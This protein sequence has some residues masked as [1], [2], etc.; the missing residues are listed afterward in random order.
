[1]TIKLKS[2][3]VFQIPDGIAVLKKNSIPSER[4]FLPLKRSIADDFPSFFH[5][6]GAIPSSFAP[7]Y[8]YFAHWAEPN[9]E[10][11]E[12][13]TKDVKLPC[14]KSA[15]TLDRSECVGRQNARLRIRFDIPIAIGI[16]SFPFPACRGAENGKAGTSPA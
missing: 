4:R 7:G 16:A 11:L 2:I 9:L 8:Q 10:F 12:F 15:T 3:F 1:M 14:F 6:R 5:T 13:N